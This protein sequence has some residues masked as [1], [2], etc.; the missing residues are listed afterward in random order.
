[1]KDL[2]HNLGE[3][4]CKTRMNNSEVFLFSEQ[5]TTCS[6]CGSRTEITLDL[7]ET[8]E[9]TQHRKCLLAKCGF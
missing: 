9:K 3:L 2:N 8:P 7:Y 1:M 4:N 6:K 5:P